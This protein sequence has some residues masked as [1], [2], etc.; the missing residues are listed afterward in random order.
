METIPDVCLIPPRHLQRGSPHLH[1][2]LLLLLL[3]L[4]LL[5][6]SLP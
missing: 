2:P 4:Q 3:L 1:L 6:L 5:Q